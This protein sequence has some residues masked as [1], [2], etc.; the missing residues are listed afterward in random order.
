MT[1]RWLVFGSVLLGMVQSLHAAS[2]PVPFIGQ[3]LTPASA[4]PGTH[5]LTLEVGGVGFVST[6]QVQWNGLALPTAFVSGQR[7]TAAVPA[8]SLAKPGSVLITVV[9]PAPGGGT[10]NFVTFDVTWATPSLF[11]FEIRT[12]TPTPTNSLVSGDFNGDGKLDVATSTGATLSILLGNGDGTFSVNTYATTAQSVG[13]LVAGDFNGDGK[14]DLAFPDPSNN[15][16]HTLLGNGDGTFT[17]ISTTPTGNDPVWSVAGDFNGDGKLDIAVVNLVDGNVSILLGNGDGTLTPKSTV[18]VGTT[19]NTIVTADLNGDGILDLAVVNTGSNNVS[20]LL[21]GGDGT[22]TLKSS[23][24]VGSSPFGIVAS[25]FSGDGKVDLAVTNMCG[26][27]PGC[28][29]RGEGS[30]SILTGA[31]DGTFSMTFVQMYGYNYP[32]GIAAGDFN[33]DGKIDLAVVGLNESVAL[34]FLGNGKG[35]FESPIASNGFGPPQAES[36]AV[37]DFNGDGRLDFIENN[38]QS[39]AGII[40][41]SVQAQSAVAFYPAVLSFAPQ[42]VGTSSASKN[43]KFEN[44]GVA[45]VK[46]SQM[47]VYGY[48]SGTNN[49]PATLLVGDYCDVSVTFSPQFVGRTG[50]EVYVY[51]DAGGSIQFGYLEGKGK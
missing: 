37:G 19:P 43:M 7:L 44:V 4:K 31:G 13:T 48:Y 39:I 32:K 22:F 10:S 17:E 9:N 14:L 3:P 49:C 47:G 34:V 27:R 24:S 38:P 12:G 29:H 51:D 28:T 35:R 20:I 18:N 8:S 25:D 41:V 23:P 26:S 21:G 15:L 5:G 33:G 50:G 36:V 30:L 11:Q 45:P 1:S 6:S 46:I 40:G 16:L 2:N 42:S